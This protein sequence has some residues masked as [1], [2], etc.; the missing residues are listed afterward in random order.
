MTHNIIVETTKDDDQICESIMWEVTQKVSHQWRNDLRKSE[1]TAVHFRWKF[2]D[3][4][5]FLH[6]KET[7]FI[8]K[9]V[10]WRELCA[11]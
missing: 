10:N 4:V 6:H 11:T 8:E 1:Q 5:R 7:Q 9:Y 2:N 3:N